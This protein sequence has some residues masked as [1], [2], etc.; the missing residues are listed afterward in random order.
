LGC[1]FFALKIFTAIRRQ[2]FTLSQF[3]LYLKRL[4]RKNF[5]TEQQIPA[6]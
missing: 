5:K 3:L 1:L 2:Y 4:E 6:V